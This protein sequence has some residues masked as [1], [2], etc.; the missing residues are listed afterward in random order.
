MGAIS[1]GNPID[2]IIATV[3]IPFLFFATST[4]GRSAVFVIFEPAV[5]IDKEIVFVKGEPYVLLRNRDEAPCVD[6]KIF[7][8]VERRTADKSVIVHAS[9]VA[10]SSIENSKRSQVGVKIPADTVRYIRGNSEVWRAEGLTMFVGVNAVHRIT[11]FRGLVRQAINLLPHMPD[12]GQRES[13]PKC[14]LDA[15]A[16]RQAIIDTPADG[17]AG[18]AAAAGRSG[19][20]R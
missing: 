1:F 14:P 10:L 3:Y 12:M 20:D 11:N 7:F 17:V 16:T 4:L 18:S 15:A 2:D 9:N 19:S 13:S 5:E 8:E 6:V